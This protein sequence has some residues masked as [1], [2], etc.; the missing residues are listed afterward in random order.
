[1][2]LRRLVCLAVCLV[3]CLLLPG[4][5]GAELA[6][7][8]TSP[9]QAALSAYLAEVNALLQAQGQPVLNSVFMDTPSM[10]VVGATA[11]AGAEVP[12]EV[13]LT[14]TLDGASVSTLQLRCT[15]PG[16]FLYLAAACIQAA[17]PASPWEEVLKRVQPYTD[18]VRSDPTSSFEE[19]I[20]LQQGT[21]PRMYFAY[22]PNQFQDDVSW[23]QMTLI[24]PL[25][26]YADDALTAV[27]PAVPGGQDEAAATPAVEGA[28]SGYMSDDSYIHLETSPV[29]TPEPDSPAGEQLN[30]R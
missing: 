15:T 1:M 20:I 26:G 14:F 17:S 25:P 19:T 30:W 9:A 7:S 23:L 12:E 2:L 18:A 4:A 13:E 28:Y 27:S 5:A 8:G 11:E 29:V 6:L 22:Y 24:F 3:L 21:A 10:V 16:Q